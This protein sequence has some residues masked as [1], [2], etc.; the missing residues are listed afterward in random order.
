MSRDHVDESGDSKSRLH[1]DKV[2]KPSRALLCVLGEKSGDS[3]GAGISEKGQ[4]GAE[5][6]DGQDS[7]IEL[8]ETGVLQHVAPPE[9]GVILLA[10]VELVPQLRLGRR[11]AKTHLGE[12][13]VDEAGIEAGDQGARHGSEED[14]AGDAKDGA[15]K[16]VE[17]GVL[18][19]FDG[20]GG[21]G[22][23]GEHAA[24]AEDGDARH[25]H[26]RVAEEGSGQMSS[27]SVLGDAGV[28]AGSKEIVLETRLDHPPAD[29]A[30]DANQTGDAEQVER[31]LGRDFAASDK[32][33]RGED[34]GE[35]DEAAPQPVRPFH[36]VDLLELVQGHVRVEHLELRRGAVL[37]KLG[38]P[39]G[40]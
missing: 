9:V 34:E 3:S 30:L 12:L 6:R 11:V 22:G 23:I 15:S 21:G 39:I 32:V 36:V 7:V 2:D 33:Q 4:D 27:Q 1:S 25:K 29:E 28:R 26:P 14:E 10:G 38:F 20:S 18:D 8:D 13:V 17:G 37:F 16:S 31:H 19:C 35:A 24:S 5:G 40:S